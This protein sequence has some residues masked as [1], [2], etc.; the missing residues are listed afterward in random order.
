MSNSV[1]VNAGED[2]C[3][4][5]VAGHVTTSAEAAKANQ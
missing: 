4:S 2:V 5:L 3:A 1:Y